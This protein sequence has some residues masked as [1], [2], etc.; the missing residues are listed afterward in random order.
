MDFSSITRRNRALGRILKLPLHLISK[1]ADLPIMQGAL[2]GK[3]WVVGSS[4]HA[5]WLGSYEME[6]QKIVAQAIHRG[7]VFYD[8]GANVGIYTLLASQ[9]V[10]SEGHIYAFE[11]LPRNIRFLRRHLELNHVNNATVYEMAV[12]SENGTAHFDENIG[13]ANGRLAQEGR[14]IVRVA[15]L[16]SWIEQEHLRPPKIIKIDVEGGEYTV[17]LGARKVLT[18]YHPLIFL[19]THGT[20]IHQ[21][22]VN[23]LTEFGFRLESFTSIDG[24]GELIARQ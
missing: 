7:D 5:C 12:G 16:D 3:R 13:P 17:L 14:I 19:A 2:R 6:K 22:C 4:V 10:G 9:Y 23:L 18:T 15:S 11:P 21:Q 20:A 1:D 24:G 8:I